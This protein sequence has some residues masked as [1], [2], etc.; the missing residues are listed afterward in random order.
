MADAGELVYATSVHVARPRY[1]QEVATLAD[2]HQ[3]ACTLAAIDSTVPTAEFGALQSPV[4]GPQLT[5]CYAH[6]SRID[7]ALRARLAASD[8]IDAVG[9]TGHCFGDHV[10]FET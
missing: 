9:C 7:T 3:D 2:T 4:L 8:V 10:Y 6:V 5:T 1:V